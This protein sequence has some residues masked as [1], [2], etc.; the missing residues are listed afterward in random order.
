MTLKILKPTEIT[1]DAIRITFP[2]DDDDLDPDGGAFPHDFPGLT[3]NGTDSGKVVLT[4]GLDDR[5]VRD[6]REGFAHHVQ[7]KVVDA[8]FYEL[9]DHPIGGGDPVVLATT[10]SYVPNCIPGKYGDYLDLRIAADGT[11]TNWKPDADE[12]VES[13]FAVED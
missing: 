2:V 8:G 12:I 1:A 13:F 9:L 5:K 3:L 4:I 10:D 7:T 11:V 6:W